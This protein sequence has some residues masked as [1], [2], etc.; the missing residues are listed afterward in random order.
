MALLQI[1]EENFDAEVLESEVPVL[2]DV[3]GPRCIPCVAL[4]PVMDDL[5]EEYQDRVKVVKIV[6]PES[7]KLCASLKVMGLPTM[8]GYLDGE[9]TDRI[10]GN[11]LGA[12]DVRTLIESLAK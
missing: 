4:D 7:R 8:L 3:W 10:G 11:D 9:E 2:V 12:A 6:A 1:T 5:A